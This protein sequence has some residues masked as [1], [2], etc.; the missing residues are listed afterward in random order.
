MFPLLW[1]PP[2]PFSDTAGLS[3]HWHVHME[4]AICHTLVQIAPGLP[5]HDE[6]DGL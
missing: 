2:F 3:N 1:T 6:L 5:Q 4:T